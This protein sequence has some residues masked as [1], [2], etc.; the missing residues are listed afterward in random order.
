MT[1]S[2]RLAELLGRLQRP[3][4]QV[5]VLALALALCSPIFFGDFV[6]DDYILR[7]QLE[8]A[9]SPEGAGRGPLD[10]FVFADGDRTRNLELI[11]RGAGLPWWTLPE[12]RGAFLR[13][14]SS[15]THWLDAQLW[16]GIVVPQYLHSLA[17]FALVLELARRLYARLGTNEWIAGVAF[18][19]FALNEAHGSVVGW[20]ANRNSLIA[21]ACGLLAL[22]AHDRARREGSA[23]HGLVAAIAM[24]AG[25]AAAEFA[26]GAVAYLIAYALFVDEATLRKRALSLLPY[27]GIVLLWRL[28]YSA[29]GYGAHGLGSYID[30]IGDPLRFA[31]VVPERLV[32]L[33]ASQMG[34][35]S[36]DFGPLF[37]PQVA[38][39]LLIV[40]VV[41]V[42]VGMWLLFP[43]VRRDRT[44]RFWACGSVLAAAPIC[45]TWSS[46]RLLWFVGLGAAPLIASTISTA[47]QAGLWSPGHR[48]RGA[49]VG[50]LALGHLVAAPLQLPIRAWSMNNL[51]RKVA[52]ADASLPT[53]A[54][55]EVQT[56]VI[57]DPPVPIYA[58]YVPVRRAVRGEPA[59]KHL[60]WLVTRTSGATI[61]RLDERT[62]RV[63]V[64]RG[65]LDSIFEQHYRDP[66]FE[67]PVGHRIELSE[68]T[69]EVVQ[70]TADRRP[71]VCDFTF[72]K[73]LNEYRFFRW[74]A[75][76]Y[77]ATEAPPVGQAIRLPPIAL[78]D[79]LFR[80]A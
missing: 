49:L 45:A 47:L 80:Q 3:R 4:A 70:Q 34:G 10:L 75:D 23:A 25:L 13:P 46:D 2:A 32:A 69:V 62:L 72:R 19:V 28:A 58:S 61:E 1:A 48:L 57:L 9:P 76:R 64:D 8:G 26:V 68:M 50:S 38:P 14:L 44:M 59:P 40:A 31:A 56:F 37:P 53:D 12:A 30:P 54:G 6:L 27:A 5:A 24:A 35:P 36:A 77:Q 21:T 29:A 22:L 17:W 18:A 60:Y 39:A 20:L 66:T 42:V 78:F 7:A 71:S 67:M 43:T 63:T 15:A 33:L 11:D 79:L 41:S 73:P 74:T 65:F 51:G 52:A 16:P 55:V